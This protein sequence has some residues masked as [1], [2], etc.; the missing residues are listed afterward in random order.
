MKRLIPLL[1]L[2]ILLASAPAAMAHHCYRCRLFDQSCP[3][4]ANFG[5]E[6]CEWE[7]G[8]CITGAAC[9]DHVPG[10]PSMAPFAA[11]FT[12]A[13]VER[14]D[15]AKPAPSETRVASLETAPSTDR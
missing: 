10:P 6:W 7:E 12:V 15:E 11:D 4:N 3:Q 8:V 2:A 1:V 13:S 14:L 5:Y 9:G